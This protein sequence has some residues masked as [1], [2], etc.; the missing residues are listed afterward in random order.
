MTDPRL[1]L[2][3]LGDPQTI[4]GPLAQN[5]GASASPVLEAV[6]KV[7][8]LSDQVE[9]GLKVSRSDPGYQ[10]TTP[11][12][13]RRA[14]TEAFT[15]LFID[16]KAPIDSSMFQ[17]KQVSRDYIQY[18]IRVS[19]SY[20]PLPPLTADEAR[21]PPGS[22]R[23]AKYLV[24][25]SLQQY[26]DKRQVL[27]RILAR[28]VEV[29]TSKIMDVASTVISEQGLPAFRHGILNLMRRL[30]PFAEAIPNK[31]SI[32]KLEVPPGVNPDTPEPAPAGEGP[33][34]PPAGE[35]S[36]PPPAGEPAPAKT[37]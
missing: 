3:A 1:S 23:G 31:Q 14:L 4:L 21:L 36:E 16:R 34:P 17:L 19:S 29:E 5:P 10:P 26:G 12:E 32:D 18:T 2:A 22:V 6:N 7:V 15:I 13:F 35:G 9:D 37:G 33:E 25:G 28:T 11:E 30:W 27:T 20:T 8:S 24:L